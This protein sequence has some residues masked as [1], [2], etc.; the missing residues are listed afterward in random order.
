MKTAALIVSGVVAFALGGVARGDVFSKSSS[1]EFMAYCGFGPKVKVVAAAER[2]GD[3]SGCAATAKIQAVQWECGKSEG[4]TAR[5]ERFRK[6]LLPLART[7]CARYCASRGKGCRGSFQAPSRCG[8]ET[9]LEEALA[10]GK[11]LGCRPDCAGPA[12]SYC[13]LYDAGYRVDDPALIARQA[14]NCVCSL[15]K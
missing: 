4:V 11:R 3:F 9:D 14:P 6:Q 15:S 1:E 13:S 2:T 5:V 8:L 7:E 12:L 10:A